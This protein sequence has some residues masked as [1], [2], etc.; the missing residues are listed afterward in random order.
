MALLRPERLS[1]LALGSLE[2]RSV[3]DLLLV[4]VAVSVKMCLVKDTV[5]VQ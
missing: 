2:I 5:V 4:R 3:V 1:L